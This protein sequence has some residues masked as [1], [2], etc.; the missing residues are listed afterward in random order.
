MNGSWDVDG[1]DPV[2]GGGGESRRSHAEESPLRSKLIAE[3]DL[4]TISPPPT[5]AVRRG[6]AK[7]RTRRRLFQTTSGTLVACGMAAAVVVWAPTGQH[8]TVLASSGADV[9]TGTG[10]AAPSTTAP[11]APTTSS[12]S[13]S[14]ADPSSTN[15]TSGSDPSGLLEASDLGTGW[16][17]PA[18]IH[19]DATAL[20]V[21]GSNCPEK[22]P[23][24]VHP[25]HRYQY[26]PTDGGWPGDFLN[27]IYQFAPGTGPS[28]LA[29]VRT[30]ISTGCAHLI[31]EADKV[32][33]DSLVYGNGT[34]RNILVR[35]GDKISSAGVVVT[36]DQD[37]ADLAWL[38][39]VEQKMAVRLA[40]AG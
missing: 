1:R 31:P 18:D 9:G 15:A 20:L 25:A 21:Y 24:P 19:L 7:R 36:G 2:R 33:D 14:S 26:L 35:V 28:V 6:G 5:M 10:T 11:P 17:G 39:S 22:G 16:S 40:A 12:T 37:S 8:G 32:G 23:V 38:N 30:T 34:S 4:V 29:Q 3:A 27:S 13:G